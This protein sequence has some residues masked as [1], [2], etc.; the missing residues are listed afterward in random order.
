M[1]LKHFFPFASAKKYQM[2]LF[3]SLLGAISMVALLTGGCGQSKV[4]L[5]KGNSSV[6]NTVNQSGGNASNDNHTQTNEVDTSTSTGSS[7]DVATDVD[8]GSNTDTETN[9]TSNT[10]TNT[11]TDSDVST[12]VA[13]NPE[14][15][16]P[17]ISMEN[18]GSMFFDQVCAQRVFDTR[19]V[20]DF[21]VFRNQLVVQR[22]SAAGQPACVRHAVL[23]FDTNRRTQAFANYL[24]DRQK[25]Q[26][27]AADRIVTEMNDAIAEVNASSLPAQYK[28]DD[29]A[30]L[31]LNYTNRHRA[32]ITAAL[33][34]SRST[35][36]RRDQLYI[37]SPYGKSSLYYS[38]FDYHSNRLMSMIGLP[39]YR[40]SIFDSANASKRCQLL[41]DYDD[42][43]FTQLEN[44]RI[45]TMSASSCT[46]YECKS[47][48]QRSLVNINAQVMAA[49]AR[50]IQ[51]LN[52]MKA[53]ADLMCP[54]VG[55]RSRSGS[56][57]VYYTATE[58][59]STEFSPETCQNVCKSNANIDAL[60]TRIRTSLAILNNNAG[61]F[62]NSLF[63]AK[64]FDESCP[65]LAPEAR[66]TST[67]SSNTP[68]RVLPVEHTYVESRTNASGMK[69]VLVN[70]ARLAPNQVSPEDG[71]LA[72][73][74]IWVGCDRIT[75]TGSAMALPSECSFNQSNRNNQ[76]NILRRIYQINSGDVGLVMSRD[77]QIYFT[78]LKDTCR[79]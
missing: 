19:I 2:P 40:F 44:F 66:S 37:M 56:N 79:R 46:S 43:V 52:H 6:S 14:P 77:E 4:D 58:A 5:R 23:G 8:T 1:S 57:V 54:N 17:A 39:S 10:D 21:D 13:V 41:N 12:D 65:R 25:Q 78:D 34:D 18:I 36:D 22:L 3:G 68:S 30:L 15:A 33:A 11:D 38:L 63:L 28:E 7:T 72:S 16:P 35:G 24:L 45:L 71:S 75:Q 70:G 61:L 74:S 49:N 50:L 67:S 62:Q 69:E 31:T 53:V 51:D 26:L 20:P 64:A 48:R 32:A 47:A 29:I 60:K 42:L 27:I 73:M 9:V 59:C 76:C 55:V